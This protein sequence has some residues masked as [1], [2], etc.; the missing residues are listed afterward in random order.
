MQRFLRKVQKEW[1]TNSGNSIA[2][3]NID[4]NKLIQMEKK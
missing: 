1:Q 3:K 2:I 4:K